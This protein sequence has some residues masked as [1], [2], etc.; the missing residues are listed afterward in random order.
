MIFIEEKNGSSLF[1]FLKPK[2]PLT[3]FLIFCKKKKK[4]RPSVGT[5]TN[6]GQVKKKVKNY[7]KKHTRIR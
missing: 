4:N 1:L 2:K 5:D 3:V 6:R 7:K